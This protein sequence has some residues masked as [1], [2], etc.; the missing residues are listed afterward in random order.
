[1]RALRHRSP[2]EEGEQFGGG[3][4]HRLLWWTDCVESVT[5]AARLTQAAPNHNSGGRRFVLAHASKSLVA[6]L[7]YHGKRMD[8]S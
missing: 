4:V 8:R 1:M 2:L 7:T 3:F 5:M 6:R